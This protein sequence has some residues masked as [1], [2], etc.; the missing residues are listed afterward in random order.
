MPC[1]GL[2]GD[3]E[4]QIM[5]PIVSARCKAAQLRDAVPTM[6]G[7]ESEQRR[8][9]KVKS[10]SPHQIKVAAVETTST[11]SLALRLLAMQRDASIRIAV[12]GVTGSGKSKLIEYASGLERVGIGHNYESCE[13]SR[14]DV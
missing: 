1:G 3:L 4:H 10:R 13:N 14:R 6:S 7:R 9:H 12:M 11:H 8:Q 5:P 2:P